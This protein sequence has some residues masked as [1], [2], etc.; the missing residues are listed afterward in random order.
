MLDEGRCSGDPGFVNGKPLSIFY[1][2]FCTNR[3]VKFV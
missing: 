3:S 1:Y 2:A